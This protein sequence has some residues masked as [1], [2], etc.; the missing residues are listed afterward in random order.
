MNLFNKIFGGSSHGRNR[1]AASQD[2]GGAD[3]EPGDGAGAARVPAA[4]QAFQTQHRAIVAQARAQ[5]NAG[6]GRL[7]M[8]PVPPHAQLLAQMQAQLAARHDAM[9]RMALFGIDPAAGSEPPKLPHE[10]IVVGEIIGWRFWRVVRKWRPEL[11]LQRLVDPFAPIDPNL[12]ATPRPKPEP[13]LQSAIMDN[14]WQPGEIMTGAPDE[15]DVCRQGIGRKG[16]NAHKEKGPAIS[17]AML[18]V[19]ET[20]IRAQSSLMPQPY[21]IF[22]IGQVALWGEII[23]H[24]HGYRAQY[25]KVHSLADVLSHEGD[26]AELL[27]KLRRIYGV[28]GALNDA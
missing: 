8:M 25:G 6:A 4:V 7:A 26:D 13:R 23:E 2:H 27:A 18:H 24:E 10:G 20:R 19:M 17:H 28:E 16:V 1:K 21:P 12:M 15:W 5:Q 22:A 11:E 3:Q 9:M 14:I